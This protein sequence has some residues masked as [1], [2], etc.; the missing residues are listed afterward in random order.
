MRRR[1]AACL[2]ARV[3]N[4]QVRLE[5]QPGSQTKAR[6]WSG[7]EAVPKCPT[8]VLGGGGMR[9]LRDLLPQLQHETTKKGPRLGRCGTPRRSHQVK[10]VLL[11]SWCSLQKSC[12]SSWQK[13][14]TRPGKG[15]PGPTLSRCKKE[16]H[17]KAQIRQKGVGPV[18]LGV[19]ASHFKL[20][21]WRCRSKRE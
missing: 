17:G 5:F 1:V 18:F 10:A 16:W 13:L 15:T 20:A 19:V 8:F 14:M 12:A 2:G 11:G 9:D 4:G 21:T 7:C 3:G 6:K